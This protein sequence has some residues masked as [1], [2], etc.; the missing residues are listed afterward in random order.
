MD[1]ELPAID[2]ADPVKGDDASAAQLR[3]NL[4]AS[5]RR[6]ALQG[7]TASYESSAEDSKSIQ[8]KATLLGSMSVPSTAQEACHSSDAERARKGRSF[9][10]QVSSHSRV[11]SSRRGGGACQHEQ[12]ETFGSRLRVK[13]NVAKTSVSW[14]EPY[15]CLPFH[16]HMSK[17]SLMLA[18]L[19]GKQCRGNCVDHVH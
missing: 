15:P 8:T 4:S 10:A 12:N 3:R 17:C 19:I 7:K 1:I 18:F 16:F 9:Y 5:S 2:E 14:G 11:L 13:F 6:R